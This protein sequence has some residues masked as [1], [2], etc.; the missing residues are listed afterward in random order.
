MT[1]SKENLTLAEKG[2][3]VSI[4]G[5]HVHVT[6][7]MKD[8][9]AGK[10]AHLERVGD[11][12]IDITVTMDIQ[13]LDHRVDILMKYGHTIIRSHAV[14]SD[15][16]VSIDQAV[17]KLESQL[18]KYR[19]KIHDHH[20]KDHPVINMPISIWRF[21]STRKRLMMQLN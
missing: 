13:K 20:A 14:T 17:T 4:T 6:Q 18:K 11:R 15:M 9:A 5:R 21:R 8:H 19:N 1:H 10:I 16:Y 7:G 3:T 2:Y 12:I